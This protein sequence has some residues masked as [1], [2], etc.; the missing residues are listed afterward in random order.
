MKKGLNRNIT[1]CC[2]LAGAC[3]LV[4]AALGT[5]ICGSIGAFEFPGAEPILGGEYIGITTV[6]G[7][8]VGC[9]VDIQFTATGQFDASQ[10]AA[11]FQL[12]TGS[13]GFSGADLGWSGQGT[14]RATLQTDRLNGTLAP[15]DGS[16]WSTFFLFVSG[17][18]QIV[19]G[20]QGCALQFVEG[21]VFDVLT[22]NM[23]F[24]VCPTGDL[25]HDGDV[26]TLDLG[27]L[28]SGWSIPASSPGCGGAEDCPA[29]FNGDG[30][31]NSLDLGVLLS[32]W[33]PFCPLCQ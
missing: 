30:F 10:V 28:L 3:G 4:T 1:A 15:T 23:Q 19:C 16:P 18:T 27:V 29:D 2:G 20:K 21:G 5:G 17:D 25:T 24:G 22:Y 13:F 26:N 8:I 7:E 11:T 31:V 12:P 33:G 32:H 14:F 6:V 9:T